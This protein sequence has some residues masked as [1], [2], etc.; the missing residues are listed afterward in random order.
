MCIYIYIPMWVVL[1]VL[2]MVAIGTKN[3]PSVIHPKNSVLLLRP[4]VL[5]TDQKLS[6]AYD[7][8]TLLEAGFVDGMFGLGIPSLKEPSHEIAL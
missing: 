3:Q 5:V 6:D 4:R 7:I 1:F 2:P 8:L